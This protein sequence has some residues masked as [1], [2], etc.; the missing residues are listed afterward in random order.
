MS[1]LSGNRAGRSGS[2]P[3]FR[4]WWIVGVA[5]VGQTFSIAP[6]LVYPFGIFVKPLA[7]AFKTGRGS[8]SLVASLLDVVIACGAP[9][10]G[11]LVDRHGARGFITASI[12]ALAAC[13]VAL[14][15]VQPPLW[16]LYALY[17]VAGIVGMA[18]APVA[19]GRVVANWF[20]RKR[21][22]A[23][24][25]ASAGI[26]FGTFITVL[27]AQSLA[28]QVGWRGAYLG[29]AAASLLIAAPVVGVFMRGTPE[30]VGLL[31]DGATHHGLGLR[32]RSSRR[33]A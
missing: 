32:R 22:L 5:F 18:S 14:A 25:L 10:A 12:V 16:H 2:P 1:G 21:G 19:Y 29:L 31:S 3:G 30:E 9:V 4:G 7:E 20:D 24:G 17:A 11:W 33:P 26:G 28:D 8:I 27:L 6:L 15:Y 23:L 13:L